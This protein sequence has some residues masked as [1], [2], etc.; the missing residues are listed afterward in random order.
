MFVNTASP[1]SSVLVLTPRPG[2][3]MMS[4]V[5][6]AAKPSHAR[7]GAL[8]LRGD[9]SPARTIAGYAGRGAICPLELDTAHWTWHKAGVGTPS[10]P[11]C[12]LPPSVWSTQN[13]VS[14]IMLLYAFSILENLLVIL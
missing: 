9:W 13:F 14:S 7:P 12:S 4:H 11:R 1:H 3:S 8:S 2:H 5:Y 6:W 10:L